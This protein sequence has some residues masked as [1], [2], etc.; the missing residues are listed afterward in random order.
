MVT[1]TIDTSILIVDDEALVRR[2][3]SKCLASKGFIC[4]E[5]DNAD[6][7][8]DCL[9]SQ[10]VEVLFL[11]VRMPGKTGKD[12]LPEI[13]AAFPETAVIMVT[14]DIEPQTIIECLKNGAEDYIMKPFNIHQLTDSISTVIE[15]K[16]L[17]RALKEHMNLI[18]EKVD[19]Q[20]SELQTLFAGAIESLVNALEAKDRYTAGHSR[21]VTD[22]S[23]RIGKTL[24]LSEDDLEDVRW[25]ALL[26]DIGKIGIDPAIINKPDRL[27]ADEYSYILN[28]AKIGSSIVKSLVNE[29]IVDIIKHHHDRFD[30]KTPNQKER[31]TQIPLGARILTLADSYDAMTSDRPYRNAIPVEDALLEIKMCTGSQFDPQVVQAFFRLV[32]QKDRSIEQMIASMP[33]NAR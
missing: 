17:E 18:E 31:G 20:T 21:R 26:H 25:A 12:F 28:H 22:L 5:A 15:K 11:D 3:I 19:R 4:Y 7:A 23:V 27:T 10:P 6:N 16:K 13:K 24:K 9:R 30:G 29:N 8:M 1:K 14:A 33:G 2:T 32:P